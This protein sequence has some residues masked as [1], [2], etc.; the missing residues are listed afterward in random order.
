MEGLCPDCGACMI[1]TC[2]SISFGGP[3]IFVTQIRNKESIAF[4][5]AGPP[6][7]REG[8]DQEMEWHPCKQI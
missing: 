3:S 7:L 8:M 1:L 5:R 6:E 4:W 2:G